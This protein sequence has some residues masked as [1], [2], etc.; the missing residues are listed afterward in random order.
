VAPPSDE[1][2]PA[3][4]APEAEGDLPPMDGEADMEGGE[5]PDDYMSV[6]KKM[7]GKLQ[8]KI[9]KYEDRLESA[10]Y[11]EV[12]KQVLSAV[13]LNKLEESDKE[14]ILSM[15][16]DEVAEPGAEP[17]DDFPTDGQGEVPAPQETAEMDGMSM[18]DGIASLEELIDTPFGEFEDDFEDDDL[19]GFDDEFLDDPEIKKAEKMAKKDSKDEF[20]N[21]DEFPLWEP[22][23]EEV[24]ENLPIQGM[25]EVDMEEEED[26]DVELDLDELTDMVNSSVRETLGKYFE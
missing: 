16:E 5:N 9:N 8:Q 7:A 11:K 22:K 1:P 6:L 4:S 14:D 18:D 24:D 21:K 3:D 23:G 19:E 17:M 13:D 2:L 20:S 10:E 25:G 15:F 12:I 26:V